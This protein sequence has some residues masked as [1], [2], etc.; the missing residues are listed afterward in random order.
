MDICKGITKKNQ[1]CKKRINNKE[2]Y[3]HLHSEI[4][5]K[6]TN[7]NKKNKNNV[8][9]VF[10]N[11]IIENIYEFLDLQSQINLSRTCK[12]YHVIFRN[13]SYNINM[14]DIIILMIRNR[15][16]TTNN[17]FK[18]IFFLYLYYIKKKCFEVDGYFELTRHY[19]IISIIVNNHKINIEH[20][21]DGVIV[22][23]N[24]LEICYIENEK[25]IIKNILKI[26]DVIYYILKNNED[27]NINDI[28]K[29]IKKNVNIHDYNYENRIIY[30]KNLENKIINEDIK[31]NKS[32]YYLTR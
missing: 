31:N 21:N 26:I 11:E 5:N 9:K 7:N 12:L 22:N 25:C 32:V 8:L 16:K 14:E 10:P 20:R 19:Y 30:F 29:D 13:N 18:S 2:E 1:R 6:K 17:D 23:I 4:F 15:M 3:C 28:I 27:Y 24:K